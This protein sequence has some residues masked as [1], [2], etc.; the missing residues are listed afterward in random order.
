MPRQKS[1]RWRAIEARLGRETTIWIGTARRDGRPHLVPLW[2]VWF[3]GLIYI[4]TGAKT[5]KFANMRHNQNVAIALP[6]TAN[7]VII[8]GEAHV[9]PRAIIDQIAE[10]F[11][12]KYEWDFRYDKSLDWRL[13]EIAPHKIIAWGDGYEHEGLHV[14]R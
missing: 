4:A 11:F 9:A 12:H 3:D 1:E 10:Q 2:F 8:E 14:T 13:V 5:Q 7:V 6:D